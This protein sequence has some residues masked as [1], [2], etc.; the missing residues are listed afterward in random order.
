MRGRFA[1]L[2]LNFLGEFVPC[3]SF[4]CTAL[5]GAW[6]LKLQNETAQTPVQSPSAA[7]VTGGP[8]WLQ[9][10]QRCRRHGSGWG[11]LV[12][13]SMAG[14]RTRRTFCRDHIGHRLQWHSPS[15]VLKTISLPFSLCLRPAQSCSVAIITNLEPRKYTEKQ[16]TPVIPPIKQLKTSQSILKLTKFIIYNYIN[17]CDFKKTSCKICPKVNLTILIWY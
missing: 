4:L 11:M 2:V 6:L 14:N 17:N 5:Y 9:L 3:C 15:K 13:R 12:L 7:V 10:Q 16:V 1:A 8:V